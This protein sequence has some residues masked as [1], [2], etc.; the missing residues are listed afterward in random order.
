MSEHV[1]VER[2]GGV[3]AIT[4]ARPERRNAIT[5]AMYAALADAIEGAANDRDVQVV[6]IRGDGQDFAA[7]NDLADFLATDMR[8]EEELPVTRLLRILAGNEVPIVAAVHGNCVGIGTTMLLHCDLVIAD[9]SARFS[10]PFVDLGLVPEA[11][12]SLIFPQ[13]AGRRRAARYLLLAEPFGAE[14]AMD[15]G[16]VSHRA[17]NGELAAKL[18]EV[19]G[20]LL[21]KPPE[22]LRQTQKLL[23]RGSN[24]DVA[25]RMKLESG[26]FGERLA[27]AEVKAAIGAFFEKRRTAIR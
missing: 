15:I 12:S 19:V 18:E 20:R 13:L 7:G 26:M 24:G 14:E 27:S 16:L 4:L 23:R 8:G 17:E 10:M 22:A 2:S 3:L 25:E 5:V 11:A 9:D 6:T 21:A 1:K